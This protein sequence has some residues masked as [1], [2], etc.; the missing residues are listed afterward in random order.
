MA[1]RI[2]LDDGYE[3]ENGE[4]KHRF[5]IDASSAL[6]DEVTTR[7]VEEGENA[8]EAL[9]AIVAGEADLPDVEPP[10]S[11]GGRETAESDD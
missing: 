11:S 4:T 7:S 10:Q 8:R 5:W 1:Q 9:A 3:A 2:N 6:M